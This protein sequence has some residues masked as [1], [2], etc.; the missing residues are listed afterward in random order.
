MVFIPDDETNSSGNI[1]IPFLFKASTVFAMNS[2]SV[3]IRTLSVSKF[4]EMELQRTKKWFIAL[5]NF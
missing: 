3:D 5:K 2:F 1:F 4:G